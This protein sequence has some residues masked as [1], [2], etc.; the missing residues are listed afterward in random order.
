M[1]SDGQPVGRVTATEL[2]KTVASVLTRVGEGERIVVTRN[3][4]QV[5]LIVSFDAGIELML[6]G[7][8]QFA[9]LRRE[10][11]EELDA[12]LAEALERWRVGI[13]WS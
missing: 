6:S 5:A 11:R 9:A 4:H 1:F 13:G 10:A 3:G 2:G 7:S 8:E 12:G